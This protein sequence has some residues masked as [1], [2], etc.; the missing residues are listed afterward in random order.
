MLFV[1]IGFTLSFGAFREYS[2]DNSAFAGNQLIAIT[3]VMSTVS[4]EVDSEEVIDRSILIS[5]IAGCDLNLLSFA[6]AFP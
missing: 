3:G 6:G 2:F 5:Y 1:S 4:S